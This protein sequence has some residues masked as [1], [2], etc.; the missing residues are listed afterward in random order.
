MKAIYQYDPETKLFSGVDIIDDSEEVPANATD[1]EPI[2]EAGTGLYDPKWDGEK[3]VGLT[4]EKY[5]EKHK[6]DPLPDG[7]MPAGPTEVEQSVTA[8]S[9]QYAETQRQVKQIQQVLTSIAMGG[10]E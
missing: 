6:N 5:E 7:V 1:V 8:L 3:W 4:P 10:N 9:Q 2:G